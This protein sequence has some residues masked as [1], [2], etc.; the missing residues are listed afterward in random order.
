MTLHLTAVAAKDGTG[1]SIP[2]GI[3]QND[4]SGT[5]TGPNV[6]VAT[7][8]DSTGNEIAGT[9]TGAAVTTDANGT[10]QQYL[11]GLVKQIT[12][13]LTNSTGLFA[14][15][16][17]GT[18]NVAVKAAST[19]PVATDP[20][21]VVAISPN[22]VNANV[23]GGAPVTVGAVV[24]TA[25]ANGATTTKI[26]AAA[27]TNATNLKA[28]AGQIYSIDLFNNAAYTVY[29]RWFNKASAPTLGTDSPS[30]VV[31]IAAGGG[32]SRE[33]PRGKTMSTGI[34]FAITKGSADLDNTAVAALDVVGSIDW[35]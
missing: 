3:D 15:L 30:W 6:P 4:T 13:F 27:T 18:N 10:L 16:T 29:F 14:R 11:R 2:G 25:T 21:I 33:F 12:G 31:P 8:V 26:S 20:A 5:G 7:L 1:T 19:A 17:D 9:T 34:S 23:Q 28:S 24:P 22:S 35:M 32:F